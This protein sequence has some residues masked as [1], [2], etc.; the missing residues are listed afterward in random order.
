M[1]DFVTLRTRVADDDQIMTIWR[2]ASRIAHPFL[3]EDDLAAQERL[4]L[5]EHLP[6]ADV[7][8]AERKGVVVGFLAT[9]GNYIGALFVSPDAQ[10]SGIGRRLIEHA[11]ARC[12]SLELSV[13][14]ANHPARGFYERLGFVATGRSDRDE[15]G[16]PL[17]VLRFAWSRR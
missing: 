1:S 13:Y 5:Q 10:G 11:Q 2:E 17:P 8:V 4:T 3:S 6:R 14:E 12:A 7:V 16:R 15:E 9:F